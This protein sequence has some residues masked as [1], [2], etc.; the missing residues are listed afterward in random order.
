MKFKKNWIRMNNTKVEE[1][2]DVV[3]SEEEEKKTMN[4]FQ[5]HKKGF[6]LGTLGAFA[7]A[8]AG[9][10]IAKKCS[11]DYDEDDFDNDYEEETEEES[12]EE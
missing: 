10:L 6:L 8:C 12:T 5:K 7:A 3:E 11:D 9:L 1:N 4:F 2:T